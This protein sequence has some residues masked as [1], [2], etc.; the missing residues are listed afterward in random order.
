MT[1]IKPT[2][3][4]ENLIRARAKDILISSVGQKTITIN[5]KMVKVEKVFDL[6]VSEKSV[7]NDAGFSD[8][9]SWEDSKQLQYKTNFGY[10]I[11]AIAEKALAKR[12]EKEREEK[13]KGKYGDSLAYHKLTPIID[14]ETGDKK[15]ID[16]S[17]DLIST[18]S[19]NVWEL[20]LSSEERKFALE[21][22]VNALMRY[23]PYN[24]DTCYLKP[25]EN[26]GNVLVVN[27]YNPPGWRKQYL[28]A[29]E[30]KECPPLIDK[31]LKHLFPDPDGREYVISWMHNALV[32]R[33][34]TYLVLNSAK[35]VGKGVFSLVLKA[36][37]GIEN[38]TE[39]SRGFLD[40]QFNSLLAN[41]RM[42]IL[43]EISVDTPEKVNKL[44]S[45]INR[46]Q[47]LEGKFENA[48]DIVELFTNF[49]ISN[50]STAD[51]HLESDDRRFSVPDTTEIELTKSMTKAEIKELNERIEEDL[52]FQRQ[53]GFWI[54]HHG[55]N[56]KYDANYIWKGKKYDRLVYSSLSEWAK[57]L[58]DKLQQA[59]YEEEFSYSDLKKQYKMAQA[60]STATLAG[61]TKIEDL[62]KN[63]KIEGRPVGE[64][65][66][67][68]K[69]NWRVISLWK[70]DQKDFLDVDYELLPKWGQYVVNELKHSVLGTRF[71]YTCLKDGYESQC[72]EEEENIYFGS[73]DKIQ[74][75]VENFRLPE[76]KLGEVGINSSNTWVVTSCYQK[77]KDYVTEEE[78]KDIMSE[79]VDIFE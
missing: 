61:R 9:W 59:D 1:Y 5:H 45:Y 12:K 63:F 52:E 70:A 13:P 18:V 8:F 55:K 34:E 51:M 60:D 39:A 67:T 72:E 62:L 33:N 73:K 66:R 17:T 78:A 38:Y 4:A 58:V 53:F 46:Y 69:R 40:S 47:N 36:L 15:L 32:D 26:L 41:R 65:Y 57:F 19:Y 27:T 64:V 35:G 30:A 21:N 42:V 54:Y 71:T 31:L 48:T 14:V 43:D 75:L 7:L 56:K 49:V 76:S 29:D 3:L 23:D 25:Y 37:V 68:S 50:N 77:P 6:Y 79:F 11:K 20:S 16:T 24:L 2:E 10:A 22:K 28:E 74:T 44:K